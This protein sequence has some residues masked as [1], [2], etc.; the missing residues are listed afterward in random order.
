MPR[1]GK[2]QAQEKKMTETDMAVPGTLIAGACAKP[3]GGTAPGESHGRAII[4]GSFIRLSAIVLLVTL[5]LCCRPMVGHAGEKGQ[6]FST[7]NILELD[8]VASAWLI[9]RYV[10][11]EARF[12]FFPEGQLISEGIAYDTPD[13]SMQRTHR[14][15]TFEAVKNRYRISDPKLDALTRIVHDAEINF[16]AAERKADAETLVQQINEIIKSASDNAA[17]LVQCFAVFDKFTE[18]R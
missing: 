1:I 17:C 7:G 12:K 3:P 14:W 2:L 15:S 16:W 11:P 10:D 8:R 13:A 18:G 5:M 6:V 4:V 9:K